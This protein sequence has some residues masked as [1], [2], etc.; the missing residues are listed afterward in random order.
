MPATGAPS[1]P[2]LALITPNTHNPRYPAARQRYTMAAR[3]QRQA[4]GGGG[5][6]VHVQL[7]TVN[8]RQLQPNQP[9]SSRSENQDSKTDGTTDA[10]K[11]A[12]AAA[13]GQR[14]D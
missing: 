1:Q 10:V 2:Q 9:D 7:C 4:A 8:R 13:G 11:V 6:G 3:S 5:G 12:A 14:A